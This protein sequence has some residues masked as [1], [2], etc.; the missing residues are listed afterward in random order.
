MLSYL[1]ADK[2][3]ENPDKDFR[4]TTYMYYQTIKF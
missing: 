1:F 3:F 2:P 4:S